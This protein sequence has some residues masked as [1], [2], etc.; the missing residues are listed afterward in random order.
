MRHTAYSMYESILRPIRYLFLGLGLPA[1]GLAQAQLPSEAEL[2]VLLDKSH[3]VDD[4][5]KIQTK[6]AFTPLERAI[7]LAFDVT[8]RQFQVDYQPDYGNSGWNALKLGVKVRNRLVHPKSVADLEVT[9]EEISIVTE[10]NSWFILSTLELTKQCSVVGESNL[11][12]LSQAIAAIPADK[13][14]TFR[15]ALKNIFFAGQN[16]TSSTSS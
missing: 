8:A 10:A 2:F 5:G 11:K 16:E 7:K 15:H 6:D 9:D 13:A 14:E 3:T 4:M 12:A 1:P